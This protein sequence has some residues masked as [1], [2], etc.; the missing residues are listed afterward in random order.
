MS[1]VSASDARRSNATPD[2]ACD[3]RAR[4]WAFAFECYRMKKGSRP[5]APND[6]ER[7][8]DEIGARASTQRTA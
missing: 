3:S 2:Y 4:A 8:S 5:G 7:R 1:E 6:A